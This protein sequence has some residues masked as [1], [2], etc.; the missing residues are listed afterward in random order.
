[1]HRNKIERLSAA[2]FLGQVIID[3]VL[4]KLA[5]GK[6]LQASLIFCG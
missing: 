6:I 1:M 2:S 3:Y 4:N 5:F